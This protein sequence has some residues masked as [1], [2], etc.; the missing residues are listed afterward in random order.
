MNDTIQI[1]LPW[2]AKPLH[3]NARAPRMVVA[4]ST[5]KARGDARMMAKNAK[6]PCW[7]TA[8]ILI[9]YWPPHRKYD[10]QNCGSACKA[11]LDGIADAMG[12]NDKAFKVDYPTV[13]A[14]T[15]KGGEVVFRVS[16]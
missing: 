11:Y 6:L 15:R 1:T 7:P 2:P 16:A 9:E 3:S 14:G 5:A 12:C 13:F 4:K 10:C 8:T